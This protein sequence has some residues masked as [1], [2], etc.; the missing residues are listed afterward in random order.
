M[1]R[2]LRLY[3]YP[4]YQTLSHQGSPGFLKD[5]QSFLTGQW[6]DA[7]IIT[8]AIVPTSE[9]PKNRDKVCNQKG[10]EVF[11]LMFYQRAVTALFNPN[12]KCRRLLINSSMGSG[13][14]TIVGE[15]VAAFCNLS[16]YP[17]YRE[18]VSPKQFVASHSPPYNQGQRAVKDFLAQHPGVPQK[19][20]F[21]SYQAVIESQMYRDFTHCPGFHHPFFKSIW[22][23]V[24]ANILQGDRTTLGEYIIKQIHSQ[25][26]IKV[27]FM[28]LVRLKNLTKNE[29]PKGSCKCQASSAKTSSNSG[30]NN[31]SYLSSKNRRQKTV[32][33]PS[34]SPFKVLSDLE[35]ALLVFDEIHAIFTPEDVTV[36]AHQCCFDLLPELTSKVDLYG[37]IGLT[38][39]PIINS[40]SNLIDLHRLMVTG[41]PYLSGGN[42]EWLTSDQFTKQ[43]VK[44]EA[45]KLPNSHVGAENYMKRC[46]RTTELAHKITFRPEAEKYLEALFDSMCHYVYEFDASQDKL[47]MAQKTTTVVL[48]SGLLTASDDI[49][50]YITSKTNVDEVLTRWS[51]RSFYTK[52]GQD[53]YFNKVK[54]VDFPQNNIRYRFNN[55]MLIVPDGGNRYSVTNYIASKFPTRIL[56]NEGDF[57]RT[58]FHESPVFYQLFRKL[59]KR[60]GK[61]LIY[62]AVPSKFGAEVFGELMKRYIQTAPLTNLILPISDSVNDVEGYIDSHVLYDK[63]IYHAHDSPHNYIHQNNLETFQ[64]SKEKGLQS[65]IFFFAKKLSTGFSVNGGVQELHILTP[66]TPQVEGRGHRVLA[67]CGHEW[68]YNVYKY[69]NV[70]LYPH[71]VSTCDVAYQYLYENSNFGPAMEYTEQLLSNASITCGPHSRLYSL[72]KKCNKFPNLPKQLISS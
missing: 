58:L 4:R 48:S 6:K 42:K 2:K 17:D 30:K 20:V 57:V 9:D 50:H 61:S 72:T 15:V 56:T 44:R 21:V 53:L 63:D 31:T 26:G 29:F 40:Y 67:H 25:F 13:K 62:A 19:I 23:K 35:G 28:P 8:P 24:P 14:T 1:T 7:D 41:D 18:G 59:S 52:K 39:T 34:A 66:A 16:L 70:G 37:L 12:T 10:A 27:T 69:F 60:K 46:D 11:D 5:C 43:Y 3:N 55:S 54:H 68:S 36:P 47:R 65:P 22:T 32:W 45:L 49:D 51:V 33:Y 64:N 71:L 38:G